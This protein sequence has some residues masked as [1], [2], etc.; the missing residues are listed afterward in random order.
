MLIKLYICRDL[1]TVFFIRKPAS[2]ILIANHSSVIA[3]SHVRKAFQPIR[4]D[5]SKHTTDFVLHLQDIYR[6]PGGA[7]VGVF[8]KEFSS[9]LQETVI[10]PEEL[11]IYGDFN[12]HM[13]DKAD[14]DATRFG[15]L[16]DLFNLKQ[17]VCVST[18]KRGHILD[19]VISRNE[20]ESASG[21]KNVTVR[22]LALV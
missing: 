15:E 18:H 8:L 13:D 5:L 6:P 20:T 22:L 11:L 9:L 4:R 7:S 1:L 12:F 3:F 2:K 19:L 14:W 16:L 21:L 17:H 10:C